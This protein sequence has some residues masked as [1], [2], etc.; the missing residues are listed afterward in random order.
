MEH[1]GIIPVSMEKIREFLSKNFILVV[2]CGVGILLVLFSNLFFSSD[3]SGKKAA[4]GEKAEDITAAYVR[5]MT[6]EL[7]KLVKSI[8]GVGAC[9]V[10]MTVESSSEYIYVAEERKNEQQMEETESGRHR[11]ETKKE[12]EQTYIIINDGNGQKALIKTT[13][14]PKVKGVVVLCSGADDPN[15]KLRVIDAVT[16]IFGISSSRVCVVKKS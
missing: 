15:V 3:S 6:D 14:L 7:K 5:Q 12:G 13:L 4:V 8:E 11:A 1:R 9:E 2:F 16:T 10:M